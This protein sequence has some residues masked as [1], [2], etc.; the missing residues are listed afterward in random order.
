[1]CFRRYAY[2]GDFA[3]GHVA[4]AGKRFAAL[5]LRVLYLRNCGRAVV[6][7]ITA[8]PLLPGRGCEDV[9][10]DECFVPLLPQR[11]PY[12]HY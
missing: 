5:L 12:V 2:L 10:T 9:S 8:K 4:D 6:G 7:G 1:M 11:F 3:A